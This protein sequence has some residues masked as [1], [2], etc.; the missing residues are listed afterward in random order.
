M[1]R[2]A[3]LIVAALALAGPAHAQGKP[4]LPIPLPSSPCLGDTNLPPGCTPRQTGTNI[5][6]G[7]PKN[8]LDQLWSKIQQVSITDLQY[9]KALADATNTAGGKMRSACWGAWIALVQAQQGANAVGPDGKPIGAKPDPALF[10]NFEQLAE[11]V[12]SLQPTSPFMVACQPV[13]N[14]IKQ[15][16]LN[17]VTMVVSGGV[18]L[19]AL[20]VAIP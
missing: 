10:T 14:T 2:I 17:L 15:S 20:G 1:K 4:K 19:G 12:D 18:S 16:V 3:L 11:V 13:A 7:N 9:A 5:L 6:T 8:D